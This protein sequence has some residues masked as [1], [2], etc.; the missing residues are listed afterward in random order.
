LRVSAQVY[1]R[2]EDYRYLA[3]ALAERLAAEAS[4]G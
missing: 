2:E 1:N 3:A 4:R